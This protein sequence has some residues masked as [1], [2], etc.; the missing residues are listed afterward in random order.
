MN[1]SP[2]KTGS[3]ITDCFQKNVGGF[4]SGNCA[5]AGA[6]RKSNT[7]SAAVMYGDNIFNFIVSD[8]HHNRLKERV[9]D[10]PTID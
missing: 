10:N 1:V 4:S 5:V 6:G 3:V 2:L 9:F 7:P 8:A